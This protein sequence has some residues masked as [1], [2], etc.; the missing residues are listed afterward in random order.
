MSESFGNPFK[1]SGE[2]KPSDAARRALEPQEPSKKHELTATSG[3]SGGGKADTTDWDSVLAKTKRVPQAVRIEHQNIYAHKL[4][5]AGRLELVAD[6]MD[7]FRQ[8]DENIAQN[9]IDA[10]LA[11]AVVAGIGSFRSENH[12]PIARRLIALG[13]SR[14]IAEHLSQFQDLDEE[15]ARALIQAGHGKQVLYFNKRFNG[16]NYNELAHEFINS[17]HLHQLG[18]ALASFPNNE[19]LGKDIVDALIKAGE[20]DAIEKNIGKFY[21]LDQSVA[22]RLIEAGGSASLIYGR[23]SFGSLDQNIIADKMLETNKGHVLMQT[24]L[25]GFS[26]DIAFRLVETGNGDDVCVMIDRFEPLPDPGEIAHKLIEHG[27]INVLA[28][29]IKYFQNLDQTIALKLIEAGYGDAVFTNMENRFKG[30]RSTDIV[31]KLFETKQIELLVRNLNKLW[32]NEE[33]AWKLIDIERTEA[34]ARSLK[35]FRGL[36]KK[37]LDRLAEDGYSHEVEVYRAAG[38]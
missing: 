13:F 26:P 17:G 5:E 9:F 22:L 11:H 30:I 14:E 15:V 25:R 12:G 16:L 34:V 10:G 33:I 28:H 38:N 3:E 19:K 21:D 2:P 37:I 32:L 4:I 24:S 1:F 35:R 23:D 8:L 7:R 27:Q 6:H 29:R 31:N 20:I 36:S 18:P